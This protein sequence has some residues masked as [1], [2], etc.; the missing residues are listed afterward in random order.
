MFR[1]LVTV[2]TYGKTKTAAEHNYQR[3]TGILV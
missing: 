2:K 3:G 1:L